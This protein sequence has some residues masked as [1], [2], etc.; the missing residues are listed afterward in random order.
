MSAEHV[1]VIPLSL[2]PIAADAGHR[3][4]LCAMLAS[5]NL[6]ADLSPGNIKTLAKYARAYAA[7]K[8]TTIYLEGQYAG[9]MCIIMKG[10]VRVFKDSGEGRSKLIA[11]ADAGN[12]LGEMSMLDGL[13]H[14]ATAVAAEPVMLV[15]L[16]RADFTKIVAESPE[17][18]TKILW[19]FARLMS[20]RLR[21]TSDM[22]V[23]SL[24]LLTSAPPTRSER[25]A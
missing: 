19:R 6:F 9:F 8:D 18:A 14:S 1:P 16:T 5:S 12:S 15:T 13:P 21:H 3:D 10:R 17:L 22:L 7:A 4:E 2:K 24:D 25:D 23:D 20:E 11:E